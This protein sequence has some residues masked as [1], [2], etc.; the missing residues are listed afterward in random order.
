M[1]QQRKI[2][3][4]FNSWRVH[5]EGKRLLNRVLK[6]TDGTIVSEYSKRGKVIGWDVEVDA[7]SIAS[8][9]KIIKG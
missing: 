3:K 7:E 9:R 5:V 1:A 8:V 2:W 6:I 4:F